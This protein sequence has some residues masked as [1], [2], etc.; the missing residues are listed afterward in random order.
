MNQ[1]AQERAATP[2]E[3]EVAALPPLPAR[4]GHMHSNGDFCIDL[5]P[6]PPQW[7]PVELFTADQMREFRRAGIAAHAAQT[8][9]ERFEAAA[10]V[11]QLVTALQE[12]IHQS[13]EYD[14]LDESKTGPT[15]WIATARTAIAAAMG[16]PTVPEQAG[17][18]AWLI[19]WQAHGYG[20]QWWGFNYEPGRHASW[21]SDA[22]NAIW[23]SRKEDGERMRLHLLAVEGLSGNTDRQRSITVTEHEWPLPPAPP[24]PE[25]EKK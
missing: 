12:A 7:W 9:R 13:I 15:H 14:G 16:W 24:A 4:V 6:V 1:A 21:C 22:N 20:P 5:F 2:A 25:Q 3:F 10:L 8:E 23:F 19:E 18:R 17:E 11:K